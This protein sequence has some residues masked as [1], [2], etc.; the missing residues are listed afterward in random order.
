MKEVLQQYWYI[1]VLLLV[2]LIV[3]IV[4]LFIFRNNAIVKKYGIIFFAAYAGLLIYFL[5]KLLAKAAKSQSPVLGQDIGLAIAQLKKIIA[6]SKLTKGKAI[7]KI[8]GEIK[9]KSDLE[10]SIESFFNKYL[11]N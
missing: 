7:E 6:E 5:I 4:V 10:A 1:P 3:G 11:H 8:N 2:V 9:I